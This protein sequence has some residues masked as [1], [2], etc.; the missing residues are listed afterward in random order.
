MLTKIAASLS[1]S[2]IQ[3]NAYLYALLTNPGIDD[4]QKNDALDE[5]SSLLTAAMALHYYNNKTLV[6]VLDLLHN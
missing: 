1:L 5:V 6:F 3:Y 4:K 2:L